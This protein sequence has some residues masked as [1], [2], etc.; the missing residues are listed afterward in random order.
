MGL[1]VLFG[2]KFAIQACFYKQC[3]DP[4]FAQMVFTMICL[5]SLY[6]FQVYWAII[7]VPLYSFEDSMTECKEDAS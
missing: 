6:A 5:L 2:V 3:V 4:V 7:G 1:Y